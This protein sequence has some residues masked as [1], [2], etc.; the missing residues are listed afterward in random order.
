[1]PNWPVNDQSVNPLIA[2]EVA[3]KND[4]VL[5]LDQGDLP[6]W[7]NDSEIA[8]YRLIS[9]SNRKQQFLA[10]H[11]LVRKLAGR[12]FKNHPGY[13]TYFQDANELRR[14][15]CVDEDSP[16]L[17]VSISHAGDWIAAAISSTPVGIDVETFQKE[18]DFLAIASHVFSGPE[19]EILKA[20]DPAQLKRTFYLY[21]TLKESIAKQFA[22]GLKFEV[23]RQYSAIPVTGS[24]VPDIQ[25][26]LSTDY[27]LALACNSPDRV[28]TNG[29]SE[30]SIHQ[31][32]RNTRA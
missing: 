23:S 11:Y 19:I 10:G 31:C 14:L 9:A 21:W 28:E 12:I 26:W 8:R 7:L 18:R 16:V 22:A 4:L 25:S 1:M 24:L 13:W 30:N 32:W 2:I 17:H 20:C 29:V 15:K 6:R 27:V 5:E 3:R